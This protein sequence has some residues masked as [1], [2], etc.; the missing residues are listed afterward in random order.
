MKGVVIGLGRVGLPV[1]RI[2]ANRFDLIGIDVLRVEGFPGEMLQL[3]VTDDSPETT[4]AFE[5]AIRGTDFILY[6]AIADPRHGR[7][8]EPDYWAVNTHGAGTVF[9]LGAK[10]GVRRLVYYSSLSVYHE[11]RYNQID[12]LTEKIEPH[13]GII[14]EEEGVSRVMAVYAHTK[15]AGE[16]KLADHCNERSQGIVL[17]LAAPRTDRDFERL[18]HLDVTH[19]DDVAQA[20]ERAIVAPLSNGNEPFTFGVFHIVQDHPD[21]SMSVERARNVLGYRPQHKAKR[22]RS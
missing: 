5:E 3:D 1:S 9:A 14:P 15:L 17:R 20:T 4:R 12:A 7:F 8:S 10:H 6:T 21:S 19:I 13:P 22:R 2:L 16:Q 11:P 18:N